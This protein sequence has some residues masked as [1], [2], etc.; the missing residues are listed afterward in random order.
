[1]VTQTVIFV[2]LKFKF[3]LKFWFSIIRNR[4]RQ[5]YP[6]RAAQPAQTEQHHKKAKT[7]DF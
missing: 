7:G 2:N 4:F 5:K 1:M 6:K 3:V